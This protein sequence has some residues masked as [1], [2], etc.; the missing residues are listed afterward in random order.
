[1]KVGFGRAFSLQSQ[2]ECIIWSSAVGSRAKSSRSCLRAR[3]EEARPLAKSASSVPSFVSGGNSLRLSWLGAK[4]LIRERVEQARP[5]PKSAVRSLDSV[6]YAPSQS[7]SVTS[8][9]CPRVHYGRLA[10]EAG[11]ALRCRGR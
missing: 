5:L 1:M 3:V 10:E 4:E 11:R 6:V 9:S 2:S 7:A 8:S